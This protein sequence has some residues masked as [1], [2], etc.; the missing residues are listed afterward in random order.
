MREVPG[1]MPEYAG[2]VVSIKW[3]AVIIFQ[4]GSETPEHGAE[5]FTPGIQG[6]GPEN[7]LW[8]WRLL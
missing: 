1:P 5:R 4:H 2:F 7:E 8:V 6:R 3:P